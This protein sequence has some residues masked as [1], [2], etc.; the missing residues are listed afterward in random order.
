MSLFTKFKDYH[1]RYRLL[2]LLVIASLYL[3]SHINT[4]FIILFVFNSV[5]SKYLF[6]YYHTNPNKNIAVISF[7]L[8][9]VYALSLFYTDNIQLGFTRLQTLSVF[10]FMPLAYLSYPPQKLFELRKQVYLCF[11]IATTVLLLYLYSIY[12]FPFFS[13]HNDKSFRVTSHQLIMHPGYLSSLIGISFFIALINFKKQPYLYQKI[14]SFLFIVLCFLSML[15]LQGR[16]NLIALIITILIYFSILFIRQKNYLSLILFHSGLIL[17]LFVLI[18]FGPSQITGRFN[19]IFQAQ[20]EAEDNSLKVKDNRTFIWKSAIK[21]I[22]KNIWTGVGIGDTEDILLHEF[23]LINYAKG[24][25]RHQNAHNQ[26]METFLATGIPGIL[27]L[28][29]LLV[30]L[31]TSS[32]KNDDKILFSVCLF[33]LIAMS[34][35]SVFMRHSGVATFC[36]ILLFLGMGSTK[37]AAHSSLH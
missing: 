32:L 23:T 12:F 26:Y 14:L 18:Q 13:D 3:P 4:L 30:F 29:L 6:K 25:D 37:K 35:E 16:I 28:V 9:F 8:F 11:M 7:L 21:A 34:T 20:Q 1:F 5:F 15:M 19:N 31:I 24:M 27:L 17:S 33:L 10:F 2:F 36:C 22:Q